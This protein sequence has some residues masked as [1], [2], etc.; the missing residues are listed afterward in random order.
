MIMFVIFPESLKIIA[1]GWVLARVFVLGQGF[2]LSLC[3]GKI[4][5]PENFPMVWS[6][7][8]GVGGGGRSDL[9]STDI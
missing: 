9:Q 7:G 6:G 5:P 8:G 3:P 4:C 2:A 1:M